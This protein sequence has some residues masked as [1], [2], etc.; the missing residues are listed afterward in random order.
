MPWSIHF[1]KIGMESH[2]SLFFL[3]L[4]TYAAVVAVTSK[5]FWWLLVAAISLIFG[6]YSYINIRVIGPLILAAVF[7][8]W[9]KE[10]LKNLR[11]A[12]PFVAAVVVI[13]GFGFGWLTSSPAYRLSQNYRLSNDNLLTTNE[14]IDQSV[15]AMAGDYSLI[16]RVANHRY[17]YWLTNYLDNYSQHFNFQFLFLSGDENL[18]HH[19]GFGGQMLLLQLPLLLIG[20]FSWPKTDKKNGRLLLIWLFLSPAV[21]AL[22]NE[23]PHASR[24]IYLMLPLAWLTGMGW[25]R[26]PSRWSMII[27]LLLLV[28]LG[29][30]AHDY[31]DHYPSRSSQAWIKPYK[32]L[33]LQFKQQLPL[34]QVYISPS[35]YKPE[36][37]LAFYL[38]DLSLLY[39][40]DQFYYYLPAICPKGAIC[41]D[42][43]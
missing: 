16:S 31:F 26:L 28:N 5:H 17:W 19:S 20:L 14:H 34:G 13:V 18:R 35:L 8:L 39:E 25:A 9:R 33:A 1:S 36:L 11:Q 30:Y 41:V 7:W 43:F 10:F 40:N 38:N 2:L 32:E 12:L 24:A 15:S 21:A 23:V 22:V 37:Y 42:Q 6:T 3:T 27:S 29:A 4:T